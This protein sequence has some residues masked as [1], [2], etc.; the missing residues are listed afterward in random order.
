MMKLQF[1]YLSI[2]ARRLIPLLKMPLPVKNDEIKRALDSLTNWDYVLNKSSITAGLYMAW[3]RRL[4]QNAYIT[5]VPE[6]ASSIIKSV[7]LRRVIEWIEQ[8]TPEL[9]GRDK[10]MIQALA[11]ALSDLHQKLGDDWR[12]W[13][14]GQT[15]Y[16]HVLIKHPLS[17]AVND[18]IRA[19]LEC[20]PLPR[21][22]SGS[23]PGVTGNGDNQTHG[24][25]FRMVADLS[26][27]DKTMF[28][29]TP[30]QSGNVSSSFYI[31]LFKPWANDQHFPVYFSR[32]K[33]DNAASEK[34]KLLP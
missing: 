3:E 21:G 9:K 18:S 24:A 23:T 7:S 25:S 8:D 26:D 20:G 6:Q 27:W 12:N 31:N 30:G 13:Q 1:D 33:I 22:G 17:N 34:I 29:N 10:F 11:D 15:S 2:P 4:I 19:L 32:N 16:H 28:T 5:M 14:Y